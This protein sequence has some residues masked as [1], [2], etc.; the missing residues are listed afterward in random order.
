MTYDVRRA[1][2]RL[3]HHRLVTAIDR[4][5][6]E[7]PGHPA[8]TCSFEEDLRRLYAMLSPF[9]APWPSL[10]EI[11]PEA[12]DWQIRSEWKVLFRPWSVVELNAAPVEG[13]PCTGRP[14]PIYVPGTTSTVWKLENLLT[15][16]AMRRIRGIARAGM[17]VYWRPAPG[18]SGAILVDDVT[19]EDYPDTP[20]WL[21]WA[22]PVAYIQTSRWKTQAIFRL[23]S[24]LEDRADA[25]VA[26]LNRER[27][28]EGVRMAGH[29]MRL[30]G[31]WNWKMTRRPEWHP[32]CV[33][34]LGAG[35]NVAM[36]DGWLAHESTRMEKEQAR[37]RPCP[38]TQCVAVKSPVPLQTQVS[39]SRVSL[40]E[41]EDVTECRNV[42]A[43]RFIGRC[44][45]QHWGDV[46]RVWAET[47]HWNARLPKPLSVAELRTICRSIQREDMEHHPDRWRNFGV[48]GPVRRA[49]SR[50]ESSA[51][52]ASQGGD[53]SAHKVSAKAGVELSS[54]ELD[55]LVRW[56]VA[57]QKVR[58]VFPAMP[59]DVR[60]EM[61]RS[62]IRKRPVP[63][64]IAAY[65]G[66]AETP[67]IGWADGLGV[68]D[69]DGEGQGGPC[70]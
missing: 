35:Q 49:L 57:D 37:L 8:S 67:P 66:T 60:L 54:E 25:L 28:D 26:F 14:G 51:R 11:S 40:P 4:I 3:A 53:V 34:I 27:G 31:C 45:A 10:R 42:E 16:V 39:S 18:V 13:F 36:A 41:P 24:G 19:D 17:H 52:L 58:G 46:D 2:G 61:L 22:Q 62:E 33:R 69:D 68:P 9:L 70:R 5:R 43:T 50:S 59:D 12:P 29:W 32:W 47:L 20:S 21:R 44:F 55:A 63:W 1:D 15:D 48:S 23:P 30:P 6:R 65:R 38:S 7:Y 64:R 56:H